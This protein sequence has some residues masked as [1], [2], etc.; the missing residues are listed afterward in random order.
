M[1]L[2]KSKTAGL[3]NWLLFYL[4]KGNLYT[5]AYTRLTK[6]LHYESSKQ[7]PQI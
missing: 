3:S 1:K 6:Q 5:D 4:N 2:P 7:I